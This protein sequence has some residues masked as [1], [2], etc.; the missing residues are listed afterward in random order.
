MLPEF[1][2]LGLSEGYRSDRFNQ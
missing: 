2:H 1:A